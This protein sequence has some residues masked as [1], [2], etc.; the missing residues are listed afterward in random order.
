MQWLDANDEVV[1]Y[2]YEKTIIEYISNKKTGKLRKYFPDFMVEYADRKELIEIKPSKRV[3]QVKVAKK[4]DAAR[5]WSATHGVTFK[6]VT[7]VE[8]MAMGLLRKVLRVPS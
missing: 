4:L 2:T 7:E 5:V 8:M 1:S 3:T 6:I